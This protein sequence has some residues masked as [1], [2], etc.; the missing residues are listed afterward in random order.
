MPKYT[1]SIEFLP[2]SHHIGQIVSHGSDQYKIIGYHHGA[3]YDDAVLELLPID[4]QIPEFLAYQLNVKP[5]PANNL[6][7]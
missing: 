1:L 6:N 2:K 4:A 7:D 5:R 3:T